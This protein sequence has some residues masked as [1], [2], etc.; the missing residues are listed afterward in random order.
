M[1]FNPSPT[2][3]EKERAL[4]YAIADNASS[5]FYEI[6][7]ERHCHTCK[8]HFNSLIFQNQNNIYLYIH[9]CRAKAL[10]FAHFTQAVIFNSGKYV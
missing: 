10:V 8:I 2:E 3:R 5:L 9:T 1:V 7:I 4:L 6:V